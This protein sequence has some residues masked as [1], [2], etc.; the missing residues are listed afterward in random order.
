LF[1]LG[2]L[3]LAGLLVG[4]TQATSYQNTQALLKALGVPALSDPFVDLRGVTAWIELEQ[5]GMDSSRNTTQVSLPSGAQ[6]G[7]FLRN[8]P[9]IVLVLGAKGLSQNLVTIW[10]WGLAV[11]YLVSIW[12]L[13][14]KLSLKDALVWCLFVFSPLSILVI[15][16][17]NFDSLVFALL[18]LAL[19]L[20]RHPFLAAIPMLA[21]GV[22]KLY[23][24]VSIAALFGKFEKKSFAAGVCAIVVF[25]AYLLL[26][27]EELGTILSGLT[28]QISTCFGV[29][30]IPNLL[31]HHELLA[32]VRLPAL[33]TALKVLAVLLAAG[34][35]VL[36]LW[37][38][39]R[40]LLN[41]EVLI[42]SLTERSEFGA[43]MG[44]AIFCAMFFTGPQMDYKWIFLLLA[45]PGILEWRKS[46]SFA[47][48]LANLWIFLALILSYWT[49]FSGE[50]SLRNALLKQGIGWA[51][52]CISCGIFATTVS[53]RFL[54][55]QTQIARGRT[56]RRTC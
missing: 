55:N 16:R 21:A 33:V 18:V 51:L 26:I 20:V 19:V 2:F 56:E 27:K 37:L 4:V 32:E 7:S 8:Y 30:V 35:F 31:L 49:F 39:S 34:S 36:G 17:A 9:P 12:L 29:R 6:M 10:G 43:L 13:A 40:I 47:G 41:S 23:P 53:I 14:G 48:S 11:V 52:Y 5:A 44:I 38:V 54:K 45:L 24:I 25:G 22:F 15:E 42:P 3:G 28:T 50:T 1:V 46:G